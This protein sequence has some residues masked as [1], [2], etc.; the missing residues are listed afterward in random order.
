MTRRTLTCRELCDF[1]AAY[2][3][4]ELPPEERA[5]FDAHLGVCPDCVHYLE[6]YRQTVRLGK[7][8][9]AAEGAL[10]EGV[11]AELVS[12]ILASRTRS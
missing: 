3:D 4:G 10:P 2:V 8:A 1:L 11:P 6:S 12:A 5:A 9:F 7:Q